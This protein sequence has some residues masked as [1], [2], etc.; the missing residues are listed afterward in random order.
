MASRAI[1]CCSSTVTAIVATTSRH[2][3]PFLQYRTVYIRLSLIALLLWI[4][5][6]KGYDKFRVSGMKN[7]IS[8][9]LQLGVSG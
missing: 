2:F 8:A 4:P 9:S 7:T 6:T 3:C 5:A 1:N